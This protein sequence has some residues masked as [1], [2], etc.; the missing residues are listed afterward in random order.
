MSGCPS[1][2]PSVHLSVMVANASMLISKHASGYNDASWWITITNRDCYVQ[3]YIIS[4]Q[5]W[6]MV[7]SAFNQLIV[8]SG[9]VPL[10]CKHLHFSH[11][12]FFFSFCCPPIG[13]PRVLTHSNTVS[14]HCARR[15]GI[16]TDFSEPLPQHRGD[17]WC[18]FRDETPGDTRDICW[19]ICPEMWWWQAATRCRWMETGKVTKVKICHRGGDGD[20]RG[21]THGG[22]P[23]HRQPNIT[24]EHCHIW[25]HKRATTATVVCDAKSTVPAFVWQSPHQTYQNV[26]A[27]FPDFS[28]VND[29]TSS[30]VLTTPTLFFILFCFLISIPTS[31]KAKSVLAGSKNEHFRCRN[32]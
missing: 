20:R 7:N 31:C 14:A 17:E 5:Q 23:S 6:P 13:R 18:P 22:R 28:L 12:F 1:V 4:R 27:A 24:A 15:Q 9:E 19:I 26:C 30:Q 29:N 8:T 16:T 25:N 2:R 10:C 11:S 32:P 3:Y 21:V